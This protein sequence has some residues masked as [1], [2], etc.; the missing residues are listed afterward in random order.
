VNGRALLLA[1]AGLACF[2]A[3]QAALAQD[4]SGGEFPAQE[5]S[6]TGN[7]I[8]VTATK[9]EQTLQDVPV[10]VT[11]TTGE[12]IER[13][14]IRD[15]NDL[16]TEVPSLRVSQNQSSAQTNFIIRGFGNGA[17]NAGVEPSVGVFVDG[18]YRSRVT[19]RIGDLP[20]IQ[21]VEV[22]RGPQSTL[23]GKNASVGVISIVTQEPQFDFGGMVEG[24]YGNFDEVVGK[25][26]ITG[27]VAESVA[28]S[29]AGGFNFR[30]GY[31]HDEGSGK[32]LNDRNRW[33]VRGQALIEPSADLKF[34]LIADY[35]KLDESCCGVLLLQGGPAAQIITLLGGKQSDPAHP[36]ADVTYNN[37]DAEN[38]IE[39]Y[40]ISGQFDWSFGDA[41]V[42]SITA[43]RRSDSFA[44]QD[45]D[46][47][48][49][50][51]IYPFT[52]DVK[53]ETFTQE[54]RVNVEIA[55]RI[56][57]LVGAFYLNDKIDQT[58][59]LK[60]S[61]QMRDY[62]NLQV[63]G[64]TSGAL[65]LAALEQTFGALDGDPTKYLGKF[66]AADTGLDEDYSLDNEA[67]SIFGQFDI[68]LVD[69]LTLTLGG[70]YT[71]DK[72]RFTLDADSSDAFAGIDLDAPQYTP[73]R[74]QVALAFGVG[75]AL[76]QS[77]PA[78]PAQIGQF[79]TDNPGVF[80][81]I[82]AGAQAA[83]V[84][85]LQNPLGIAR[86]L[87]FIPPFLDVPNSVE[88]GKIDDDD[89]SYT[90]RLAYD[91][92]NSL[93]IYASYAT[94]FKASSVNL[95]RDSRPFAEDA[96]ALGSAGLLQTNQA[97]GSRF[98]GPEE[99]TVYE[100]G[101]KGNWGG[102][103]A[104][105]AVFEQE[106]KGF[107]SNVFTGTGFLL[108][109]AGKQS[110]FG[111]EF[112][113][114]AA[115]TDAFSVNFGITYLDPKY[116]DFQFSTVG[117]LS[118]TRPSGIPE[119]SMTIGGQY[120]FALG[121]GDNI[122]ARA[123][124]HYESDVQIAEGLSGF[125]V[126]APDGSIIDAGPAQ[127]AAEP[128]RRQ[129]DELSASLAYEFDSGLSIQVWGRNLLNDRYLQTIFDTPAQPQSISGYPTTPRTY[130]VTARFRF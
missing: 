82:N 105:L 83:A 124:Y 24:T 128:F 26:L 12:T 46:F 97:F 56:N 95:S 99:S 70:N 3:P 44:R 126:T 119:I 58:G 71:R 88:P 94:G 28:V 127:A 27:P 59:E 102:I 90:I 122:V 17:N 77:G 108:A 60:Y 57:A 98:A 63:L 19:S 52:T 67:F 1:G 116:D 15:I 20:D 109:N 23:F 65:N 9:R 89:F 123:S 106:I 104:N 114:L 30:D 110:T 68:E 130:G 34:R 129:V 64:A 107:Q 100:A 93:N 41:T 36:F 7:E 91:L 85:P 42:T 80:A 21:R 37:F 117:D 5:D 39:N 103:S 120:D 8:I 49:A 115:L 84:D 76:G 45:P 13:A 50:D 87:Q 74:Y 69:G 32:D 43:W 96:A 111:I 40:G 112:E 11:V 48:S 118:G 55:D 29:L 92:N 33:W 53:A 86:P 75:Q 14:A 81:L 38:K 113:G 79:M 72:K 18:V 6:A 4:A 51:L 125:L 73:F 16:Q 62:V 2:A 10:A 47:S 78:S 25:A 35:D 54:L 61:T 121:N 22:L 31:I 101:V 66:F